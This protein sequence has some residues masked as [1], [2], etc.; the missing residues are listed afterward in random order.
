LSQDHTLDL[1]APATLEC[2]ID[3]L[4]IEQV[5][6]NLLDNAMKY[7]PD[8][9]A[10]DVTLSRYGDDIELS[11]RDRGLGIPEEKR[12]QI[13]ERF[14]QAHDNGQRGM[15]LGLYV[16]R[17]IVELHGGDMWAEFPADGGTRM[18]VR[19]PVSV[20]SP[21]EDVPAMLASD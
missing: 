1:V 2:E 17:H 6:S 18:I 11:V 14:Y 7:S 9:G 3:P 16:S 10:I 8:G 4:R 20:A 21:V 15:G 19:L 5:L 12:A 13:F